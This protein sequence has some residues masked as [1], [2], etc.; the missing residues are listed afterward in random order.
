ME[1]LFLASTP[2][3]EPRSPALLGL[4]GFL[5]LGLLRRKIVS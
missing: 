2:V 4:G 5:A 3:P 1:T